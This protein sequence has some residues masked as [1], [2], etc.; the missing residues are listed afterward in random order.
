MSAAHET[1]DVFMA[2]YAEIRAKFRPKTV[3]QILVARQALPALPKRDMIDFTPTLVPM[4]RHVVETHAAV[5]PSERHDILDLTTGREIYIVPIG[6]R[7]LT[8]GE[9]AKSI[10]HTL[11]YKHGFTVDE[12]KGQRRFVPLVRCRQEVCWEISKQTKWSLPRIGIFLGDRDHTTILHA[13]R[14][15]QARLD[16]TN[17][18]APGPI[19][20]AAELLEQKRERMREYART[21]V[22]KVR[23]PKMT[24]EELRAADLDRKR[25][26]RAKQSYE[27]GR[28]RLLEALL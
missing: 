26:A 13:V 24:P 23:G 14:A 22:K 18:A 6:P 7:P 20:S 12:V 21:K 15:H 27:A 8:D 2:R 10:L 11:A 28:A 25:V 5:M 19:L 3:N 17:K 4:V 1:P 16:G 9:K